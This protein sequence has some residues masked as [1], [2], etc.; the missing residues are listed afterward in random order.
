M[1]SNVPKWF[2]IPT[3]RILAL[4]RKTFSH[5]IF[6][7]SLEEEGDA[8]VE[9]ELSTAI[10][11]DYTI[12]RYITCLIIDL[13]FNETRLRVQDMHIIRHKKAILHRLLV[14]SLLVQYRC[15]KTRMIEKE[16]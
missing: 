8:D 1:A 6:R 7:S 16:E 13:P 2:A 9:D 15:L 10:F 5:K 12:V 11:L 4:I 14:R 3:K